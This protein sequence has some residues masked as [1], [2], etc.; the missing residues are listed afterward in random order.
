MKHVTFTNLTHLPTRTPLLSHAAWEPVAAD[1]RQPLLPF[2]CALA[3]LPAR[4]A[5]YLGFRV[6]RAGNAAAPRQGIKETCMHSR[7]CSKSVG[8]RGGICEG[9]GSIASVPT[10]EQALGKLSAR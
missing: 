7:A 9:R 6:G 2:V 3:L 10:L 5:F 1:R 4:W 8:F